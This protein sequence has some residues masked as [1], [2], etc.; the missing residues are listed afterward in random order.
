MHHFIPQLKINAPEQ[1]RIEQLTFTRFVAAMSIV[2]FHFG[3]RVFPFN[4]EHISFVFGM[5][6]IGV[7]YF[8]ILSGFIMIIAYRKHS[9]VD[10]IDYYKNRFAR[11]YP[12]YLLGL[13][14]YLPIKMQITGIDLKLLMHFAA[15]QSWMPGRVLDY[16][17]PGWSISVEML[18]YAIFPLLWNFIYSK[19]PNLGKLAV[20]ILI[21]WVASQFILN[22]LRHS[23]FYSGELRSHHDLLYYFPLMHV[24]QFLIGNLAGLFF[25]KWYKNNQ[26]NYDVAVILLFCLL[27]LAMRFPIGL[28]YHNGLLGIIFIPLI[29]LMALN[30]GFIT[31]IFNKKPFIFLG[32]ISY[33]LYILQL[34][35]FYYGNWLPIE[36]QS[37]AFMIKASLLIV[38]SSASFVFLESP[39]R[40]K[41]KGLDLK[42]YLQIPG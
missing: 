36:N 13:L 3:K 28:D 22:F 32:E 12:V 6:N 38:L 24:N 40:E 41:I 10:E 30:T 9:R 4:N 34:P 31:R 23:S 14:L 39:L 27:L 20:P 11:I 1:M 33:S 15:L 21:I 5:A 2:I 42:R 19:K 29:V 26:R 8:F 17:F 18:F 25:L 37:L 35:V 7:S 16:N